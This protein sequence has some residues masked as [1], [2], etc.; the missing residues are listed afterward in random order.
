MNIS[1]SDIDVGWNSPFDQKV[2][3][4]LT[5]LKLKGSITGVFLKQFKLE[6][7][8]CLRLIPDVFVRFPVPSPYS[9]CPSYFN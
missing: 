8:K 5:S 6:G 1:P 2:N 4:S 7:L 9:I 3:K